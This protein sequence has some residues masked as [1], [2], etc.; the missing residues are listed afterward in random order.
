MQE[1][2]NPLI[3][4]LTHRPFPEVA[5]ILRA[6]TDQITHEWDAAVRVAMPQMQHLTYDELKDSTPEILL[7]IANA[8]A[9]DDPNVIRELIN[10]APSQGL[11]RFRLN[12]DVIEVMQEDRLLRAITVHHVEE[13]LGR[14]MEVPES[15]A[16][17]VA[18]DVMLQ[19]SVIAMVDKQKTQL[20]AAA[21]TELKYLSFLSHDLNNNL[22]SITMSLQNLSLDLREAGGFVEAERSLERAQQHIHDTVAGMR[23]MLDHERLR[24]TGDAGAT[25][26]VD[27]HA[28][29]TMIS[30]Q[31]AREAHI[32]ELT[33]IVEMLPGTVVESEGDL[34]S[35]VLQNLLGNAVKYTPRGNIRIGFGPDAATGRPALWVADQGS[36]IAPDKLQPIF[37]A[38]RRGDSHGEPG[39]GLGLAIASQAA[40]LLGATLT[41]DSELGAGSTFR[42]ILPKNISP[43]VEALATKTLHPAAILG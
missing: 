13:R 22:N 3:A 21:E 24:K 7:A 23:R 9:S 28:L 29:A 39:V 42:L 34:I 36:G 40:K 2:L 10:R 18:I 4:Q 14:R 32:K 37:E 43:I 8:L 19:R 27:L 30:G 6:G 31:F 35:L 20:R 38:F 1:T 16:L 15:A 26:L 11:S 5:E 25:S 33:L 41:V 17:H 12:F